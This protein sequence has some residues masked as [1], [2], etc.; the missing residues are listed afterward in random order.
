MTRSSIPRPRSSIHK[1]TCGGYKDAI[2]KLQEAPIPRTLPQLIN[3][4]WQQSQA[5]DLIEVTDPA[6]Q[7]VI[8]LAPKAPAD[9]IEA[10]VAGAQQAC[11]T[12][13]DVPVAGRAR[14]ML[15]HQLVLKEHHAELA[16]LLGAET[17]KTFADA[18]GDV[19]RGS[20]VAEHAANIASL[21]MGETVE[22]V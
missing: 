12:W 11:L 9:E 14:V 7:D 1:P 17:G 20:E 21:M 5:T 6:T 10:A 22:H 13:R 19:W 16:E 18:K 2:Q 8:A 15:R 3:G 4:Q